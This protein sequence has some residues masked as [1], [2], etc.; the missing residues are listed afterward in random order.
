[1]GRALDFV[2]HGAVEFADQANGVGRRRQ[3]RRCVVQRQIAHFRARQLAGQRRFARL[4]RASQQHYRRVAHGFG[5]AGVE[6]AGEK[7]GFQGIFIHDSGILLP[8]NWE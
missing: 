3:Q 4:T 5:D 2:D 1:L 7:G 8:E 6:V